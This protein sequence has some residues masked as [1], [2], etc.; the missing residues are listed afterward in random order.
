MFKARR[1]FII[2]LLFAL[3]PSFPLEAA[4][5]NSL[6]N[7]IQSL[8]PRGIVTDNVSFRIVFKNP[9][10]QKSN[11]GKT[12]GTSDNLFPFTVQP[13]IQAEG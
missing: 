9:I 6:P 5:N 8:A 7:G 12:F 10:V 4:Q 2:L 1:F 11:V 13:Q 3:V